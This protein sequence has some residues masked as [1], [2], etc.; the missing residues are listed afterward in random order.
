MKEKKERME[1]IIF[2]LIGTRNETFVPE[3]A[4]FQPFDLRPLRHL[5]NAETALLADRLIGRPND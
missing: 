5:Y 4:D 3:P 2:A 1:V